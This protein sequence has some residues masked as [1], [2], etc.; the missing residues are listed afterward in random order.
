MRVK[1]CYIYEHAIISERHTH[2]E[3]VLEARV[4]DAA[5]VRQTCGDDDSNEDREQNTMREDG[6]WD[7]KDPQVI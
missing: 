5:P 3:A 2:R 7:G 1:Y 6:A 4:C